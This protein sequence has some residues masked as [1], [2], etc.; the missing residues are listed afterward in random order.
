MNNDFSQKLLFDAGIAS[1][2]KVLDIGCCRGEFTFMVSKIVGDTGLVVG[3]DRSQEYIDQAKLEATEKC[4]KNVRFVVGE[5][6]NLVDIEDDFDAI[7][8]RR[9]LMYLPDRVAILRHLKHY[10]KPGGLF[11]LNESGASMVSHTADPM[12]LHD[13]VYDWVWKV[14]E[15]RNADVY[16]GYRLESVMKQAGIIVDHVCAQPDILGY[17]GQPLH[18]IARAMFPKMEEIGIVTAEE[19]DIETLE[20]RLKEERKDFTYISQMQFGVW[21]HI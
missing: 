18:Q 6:L 14:I 3:Y 21:G 13:Q 19:F 2:M 16:M 9:V 1:G 17:G 7:V 8:C 12:P 20:E 4:V 5:L 11:V 10:L 15:S